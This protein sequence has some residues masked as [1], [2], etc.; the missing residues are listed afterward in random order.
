MLRSVILGSAVLLVCVSPAPAP[1]PVIG[2][3]WPNPWAPLPVAPAP[4]PV[5][6][7][8]LTEYNGYL[9]ES[10]QKALGDIKS[11][12]TT[13]KAVV[14]RLFQGSLDR[15]RVSLSDIPG[16]DFELTGCKIER[17]K[18]STW[19]EWQNKATKDS[20]VVVIRGDSAIGVIDKGETVRDLKPLGGDIHV[21]V[22]VSL[23]RKGD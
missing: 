16:L 23:I 4:S 3:L 20:V 5:P 18:S 9:S 2:P 11:E 15:R 21:V 14:V 8:L 17:F 13:A 7:P 12:T 10:Q 6:A 22:W 1:P 19:V